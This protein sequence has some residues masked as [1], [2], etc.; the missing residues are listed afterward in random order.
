[1]KTTSLL[2]QVSN[3]G[4]GFCAPE[5][6]RKKRRNE[7]QARADGGTETAPGSLEHM[8]DNTS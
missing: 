2:K 3:L 1:M 7:G 4:K 6:P 5:K 8:G